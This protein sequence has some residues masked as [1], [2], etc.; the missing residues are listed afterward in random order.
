MNKRQR[1]KLE[2]K[3]K[4]NLPNTPHFTPVE[5]W[6]LFHTFSVYISAGLR[7]FL[8]YKLYGVPNDFSSKDEESEK[9][10]S[11]FKPDKTFY[12]ELSKAVE[13]TVE[14]QHTIPPFNRNEK[15]SPEMQAWRATIQKMLWSFEQI[16]D[17]FPD[18]PFHKWHE[19]QFYSLLA[20]KIPPMEVSEE[21]DEYGL[22]TV[23]LNG[24]ETPQE[25]WDADKIYYEKIQ[26]GLN[27]FAKYFCNLWD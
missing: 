18:S 12:E 11:D 10:D 22:H 15:I 4:F 9:F 23:K 27:L 14:E 7:I 3:M 13:E 5:R 8:A 21:A 6:N 17:D 26:E 2:A 19:E 20:K 1:K 24:E 25:I 16:R